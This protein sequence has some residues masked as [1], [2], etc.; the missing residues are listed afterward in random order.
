MQQHHAAPT[1][2]P[3][4]SA[5]C[6]MISKLSTAMGAVTS[7]LHQLES[8][9]QHIQTPRA[10]PPTLQVEAL[11]KERPVSTNFSVKTAAQPSKAQAAFMAP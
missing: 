1:Q 9:A 3:I 11:P 6:D 10:L 7:R 8:N 4:F 5:L 2:G